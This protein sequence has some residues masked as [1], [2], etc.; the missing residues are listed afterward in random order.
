MIKLLIVFAIDCLI[1]RIEPKYKAAYAKMEQRRHKRPD[2]SNDKTTEP[3][4][5]AV[6]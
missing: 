5:K 2:K 4:D 3:P 6:F 1:N